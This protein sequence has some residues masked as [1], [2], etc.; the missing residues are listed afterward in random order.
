MG[1]NLLHSNFTAASRNDKYYIF[2]ASFLMLKTHKH[3]RN[4]P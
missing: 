3:R 1:L 4:L 2:F